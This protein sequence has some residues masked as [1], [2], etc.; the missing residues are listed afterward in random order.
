MK[1]LISCCLTLFTCGCVLMAAEGR[2]QAYVDPGSGL[3]ALQ[4]F[5]SVLAAAGF[6]LRRRIMGLFTRRKPQANAASPVTVRKE[7]SRNAA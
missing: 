3:L 4:S 5:A 7:D 2:A 6:C 1:R